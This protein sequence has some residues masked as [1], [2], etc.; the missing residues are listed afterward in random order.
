MLGTAGNEAGLTWWEEG[1]ANKLIVE[2][3]GSDRGKASEQPALELTPAAGS[4]AAVRAG[5]GVL[6]RGS[7]AEAV[8]WEQARCVSTREGR[9]GALVV[10]RGT[11][12][13]E[14]GRGHS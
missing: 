5:Q 12:V 11:Q 9:V 2:V 8:R 1:T 14:V 4:E 3:T 10:S 13:R 6:S 7:G